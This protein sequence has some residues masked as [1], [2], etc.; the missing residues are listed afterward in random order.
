MKLGIVGGGMIVGDLLAFI[1]E[2]KGIELIA[3]SGTKRSEEK[4]KTIAQ[5]HHM[6][7]YYT[8]YQDLLDDHEVDTIY[9]A[10][11][12]VLH[13]EHTKKALEAGKHVICE[14]PFTVTDEQAKE[15]IDL[16]KEKHLFLFEAIT[17]QYLPQYENI[18]EHINNL[19]KIKI[20][21]CNFSQYSSRY[22]R[23]LK[24]DIAPAFDPKQAG[25][26]LMDLNIYNIHYIVGLFGKPQD[27][28]YY[29]NID[30]GIDTSGILIM[31]YKDFKCVCIGA[32]DTKA[33]LSSNIEGTKGC[34][35]VTTP[36]STIEKYA[37]T[38]H[39][40]TT[41]PVVEN[42]HSRMYPEF[43]AF[44]K[45]ISQG[46]YEACYQRL[47]ET[48]AVMQVLTKARESGHIVFPI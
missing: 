44:E 42:R 9:V 24:G 18:K 28:H 8:D 41:Y 45:M 35:T 29:P 23:F 36:V 1:H 14:K 13:Y 4:L 34:I 19:G 47:E 10:L 48:Y 17:N 38:M 2:V 39:D 22:D 27:V 3:I 30:Q 32:K 6:K 37:I 20:I 31:D 40:G 11:P 7:R 5:T 26:A 43:A 46:Q 15:V 16:A 33:P 21:E 12:N 25:G